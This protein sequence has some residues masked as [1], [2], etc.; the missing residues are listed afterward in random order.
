MTFPNISDEQR[1]QMIAE[2]AYL[3]AE[4]RGFN[5]HNPLLDWV[6]AEAEIDA[7]LHEQDQE[8]LLADLEQ[9][10][11]SVGTKLR[12]MRKKLTGVRES[13]R[14]EW[15]RDVGTLEQ[16]RESFAAQLTE[17]RARGAAASQKSREQADVIWKEISSLIDKMRSC[18][19]TKTSRGKTQAP[20][21]DLRS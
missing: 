5:D 16:L 13:A 10:L 11:A 19:T 9:R 12:S 6:E 17:I 15:E 8:G 20:V 14:A 18:A 2:A 21:E 3:R 7:R 4:R 1:H